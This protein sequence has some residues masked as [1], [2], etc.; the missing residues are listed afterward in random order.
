MG[1]G[2]QPDRCTL[3]NLSFYLWLVNEAGRQIEA[4]TFTSWKNKMLPR[5]QNR[6]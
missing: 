3:Q 1:S 2:F 5:V 4:G 6:L